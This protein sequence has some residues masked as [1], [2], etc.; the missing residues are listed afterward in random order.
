MVTD[1]I[2]GLMWQ[3][4]ESVH[5]NSVDA[6][7]YCADLTLGGYHN[8]RLPSIVELQ[9]IVE[10]QRSPLVIRNGFLNYE[11]S[12]YRSST[13]IA[14]NSPRWTWNIDFSTGKMGASIAEDNEQ[15]IRCVR[16]GH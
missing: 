11:L 1:T 7:N 10:I 16:A 4:N 9:S 5:K 15:T 3:D 6:E 8:W 14:L 12:G 13:Q 2:T